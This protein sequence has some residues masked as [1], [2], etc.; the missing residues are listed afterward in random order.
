M[1]TNSAVS[2]P[3][4]PDPAM[5]D[6]AVLRAS[7]ERVEIEVM[8]GLRRGRVRRRRR[9]IG[10]AILT[11]A[12][13]FAGGLAVGGWA[14]PPV[15][16]AGANPGV[17][18]DGAGHVL[19]NDF[20]IDCYSSAT[21]GD[22]LM[23]MGFTAPTDAGSLARENAAKQDPDSICRQMQATTDLTAAMNAEILKLKAEGVT[24]GFI[25]VVDGGIYRFAQDAPGQGVKGSFWFVGPT[26]TQSGTARISATIVVAPTPSPPVAVCAVAGNWAA[27]YPLGDQTAQQVCGK[28]G[29]DVWNG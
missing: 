1:T 20:A 4:V 6:S 16:N 24:E 7:I 22:S 19:L 29:Y 14:L 23:T 17:T 28:L 11:G 21:G 9:V 27:V 18:E 5:P 26:P 3:I 25:K 13:L 15:P 10:L 2:N 8:H 12:G